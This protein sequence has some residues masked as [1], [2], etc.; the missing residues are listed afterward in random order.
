MISG[1]AL[2]IGSYVSSDV[3]VF[4]NL[5]SREGYCFVFLVVDHASKWLWLYPLLCHTEDSIYSCVVDLVSVKI[6]MFQK[7][8]VHFHSDGGS[9]LLSRRVQNYLHSSGVTTSHSPRDTPE[10]NSVCERRTRTLK[11]KMMCMLMRSG[12]PVPF[13]WLALQCAGWLM[14]RLPAHT[15]NGYITPYEFV[16]GQ[17]PVLKWLRIWGCKAYA[18]RP[19]GVLRKDLQE[20]T[21][22]GFLVGFL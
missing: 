9:E 7:K 18:M 6:P 12:L 22:S 13:W 2:K 21:Q 17:L 4:Q 20:K 11:E 5:P 10:M 1:Q 15:A 19:R 14:N 16:R 8:L 3:L